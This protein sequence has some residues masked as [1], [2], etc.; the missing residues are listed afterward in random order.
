[1]KKLFED[2]LDRLSRVPGVRGA[3]IV[4]AQAGVPIVEEMAEGVAGG[5]VAAMAA[6]LVKRSAKAATTAKFGELRAIQLEAA[7]GHLI[8]A[9]HRDVV[10]VAVTRV[11]A[12]LGLVRVEMR[13]V[14]EALK[15]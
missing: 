5:A 4:D 15:R 8:I 6:S 7:A 11:D 12:Q 13:N 14:L 3:M 9:S 2:M 10:A 1:M